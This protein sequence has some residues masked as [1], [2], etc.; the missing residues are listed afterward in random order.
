MRPNPEIPRYR[1]LPKPPRRF[2]PWRGLAIAAI[3][4][5][6]LGALWCAGRAGGEELRLCAAEV[7]S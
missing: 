4:I 6:C 2:W 5:A 7:A 1:L 3:L